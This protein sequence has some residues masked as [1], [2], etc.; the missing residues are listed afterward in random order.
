MD[1]FIAWL[2]FSCNVNNEQSSEEMFCKY[3]FLIYHVLF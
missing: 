1:Q 2:F 3:Y